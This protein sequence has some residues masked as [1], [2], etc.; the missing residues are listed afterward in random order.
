MSR[1]LPDSGECVQTQQEF[2]RC[3]GRA[4]RLIRNF[5]QFRG[6]TVDAQT[7][8]QCRTF[9]FR[10]DLEGELHLSLDHAAGNSR[11]DERTVGAGRR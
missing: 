11:T 7:L 1:R 6:R 8:H 4:G 5:K 9:R 10:C 3:E 2:H